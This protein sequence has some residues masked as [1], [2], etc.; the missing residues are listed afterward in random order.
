MNPALEISGLRVVRDVG[1]LL[2]IPSL[3]L[4]QA[5][6]TVVTGP[7]DSGK[8]LLAS[9]LCGVTEASAGAVTVHGR[10]LDGAPSARRRSGLAGTVGDGG[11]IAGCTVAEALRLA[12]R[13]RA[14]AV[15]ERLPI[16]LERCGLRAESLSGGEQ[17]LLQVACAWCAAPRVLVLDSPTVGLAPDAVAAVR[18]LAEQAAGDGSAVLWLDQDDSSAPVPPRWRL[19]AG[20]LSPATAGA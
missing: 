1:V 9:V 3:S 7:T 11:R 10:R 17:Q 15:L 14:G 4:E 16:L 12:G 13:A 2:D 5:S 6:V 18:G 8:T 19:D 20:V